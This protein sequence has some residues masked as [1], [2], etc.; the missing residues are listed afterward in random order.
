MASPPRQS[1]DWKLLLR[2]RGVG[3]WW[4]QYWTRE[5][6]KC[7]SASTGTKKADL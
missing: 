1:A 5:G 4:F 2:N 6:G 3:P 7:T